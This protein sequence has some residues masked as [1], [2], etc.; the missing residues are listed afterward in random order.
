MSEFTALAN[1]KNFEAQLLT[2][3]DMVQKAALRTLLREEREVLAELL[4]DC[5]PELFQAL[6]ES[7]YR[8]PLGE[9]A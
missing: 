2:S 9:R 8:H 5:P 3:S 7:T 4:A 1:I 6:R